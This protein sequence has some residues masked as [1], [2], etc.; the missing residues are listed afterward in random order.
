MVS[1]RWGDGGED[2]REHVIEDISYEGDFITCRCGKTL[3]DV[4]DG[5][6][7]SKHGGRVSRAFETAD[8]SPVSE[9][10]RMS[11][12][13]STFMRTRALCT[14]AT[15]DLRACPNYEPGDEVI[16]DD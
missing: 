5:S 3:F 9:G 2:T 11:T 15:R 16:D 14:C 10:V 1:R 7:W 4:A 12:I 8:D 13:L 6:K